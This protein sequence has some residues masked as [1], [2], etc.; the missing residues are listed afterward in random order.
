MTCAF[1]TK[2]NTEVRG[3]YGLGPYICNEC[4]GQCAERMREDGIELRPWPKVTAESSDEDILMAIRTVGKGIAPSWRKHDNPSRNDINR[5]HWV[6]PNDIGHSTH[7]DPTLLKR[8]KG[9]V[10][11]GLLEMR[12]HSTMPRFRVPLK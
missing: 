12:F 8:L 1:C 7:K 10:S 11:R 2:G 9:L 3:L 6:T 4:V 5:A